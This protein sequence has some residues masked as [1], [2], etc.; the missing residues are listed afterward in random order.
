MKS[1]WKSDIGK[2]RSRNEDFILA[3][4]EREIFLLADGMGG[5]P[6]GDVASALAVRSAYGLLAERIGDTGEE[7][8]KLL[9]AE[10]LAN[11]HSAVSRRG[12]VEPSLEGMGTTLDIVCLRGGTA[13]V[14]HVG[15]SRVYLFRR[16]E[17]LQVTTDDNL[18]SVLAQQ[19]VTPGEIPTGARHILTQAVGSS[20]ELVP[21]IRRLEL[22]NG[23]ILLMCSDGLT[24]MVPDDVI[25][26]IVGGSREDLR[27]AADRL[28]AEA[29]GR[30]G[31]D[32]VSVILVAPQIEASY[33]NPLLLPA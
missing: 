28:V 17:L 3:D 29:N 5:Q 22:G 11:A 26:Q 31:H 6:G 20:D 12:I 2:V 8:V 10:V 21:E 18:A 7:G 14:C 15:D 25:A 33:G 4:D 19:G 13:W 23:D 16:G 32:N 24:G 30:G 27:K 9:L 1:A